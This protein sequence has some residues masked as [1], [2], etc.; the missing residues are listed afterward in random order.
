MAYSRFSAINFISPQRSNAEQNPLVR[1]Y[2]HN[3]SNNTST[4][5]QLQQIK[6]HIEIVNLKPVTPTTILLRTIIG[7]I[8]KNMPTNF[9]LER[10]KPKLDIFKIHENRVHE[11]TDSNVSLT[12]MPL[13]VAVV[14]GPGAQGRPFKL[15]KSTQTG[16]IAAETASITVTTENNLGSYINMC[17]ARVASRSRSIAQQ[18]LAACSYGLSR[19][20][21]LRFTRGLFHRDRRENGE[22]LSL[23]NQC[24]NFGAQNCS[25]DNFI[26]DFLLCPQSM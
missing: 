4:K 25:L 16:K 18:T 13:R 24:A 17:S 9:E 10:L 8:P 12:S 19:E 11:L 22:K 26:S 21:Y 23:A 1:T 3:T 5:L 2:V 15:V 7:T 20:P 14:A 6:L